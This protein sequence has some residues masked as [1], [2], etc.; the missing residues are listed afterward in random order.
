MLTPE[1]D[2]KHFPWEDVEAASVDQRLQ[3]EQAVDLARDRYADRARDCPDCGT[4]P[5]HLSW[6]Y[7]R[8]PDWTW[9]HLCGR[10]GYMT[11]CEWCYRQ[12]DFFVKVMN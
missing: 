4:P 9:E 2:G 7:F 5:E 11:V 12:I 10:A 3:E 1:R 8:S 6:F